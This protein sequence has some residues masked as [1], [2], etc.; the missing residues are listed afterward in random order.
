[1]NE[2]IKPDTTIKIDYQPS[3]IQ[4]KN[5]AE[6]ATLVKNTV[7]H[8]ESLTFTEGDIQG[9]KDAQTSLNKI[10]KLLNEKRIEVK[11]GYSE[12]L[13]AF[14]TKIKDFVSQIEQAKEGIAQSLEQFETTEREARLKKV[15]VK[16]KELCSVVG[17]D[18]EEIKVPDQW[19]NKGAFTSTKGELKAAT[20]KEITD[21]INGIVTERQTL[22]TNKQVVET[23]AEAVG[24]EPVSWVRWLDQGHELQDVLDQ[25]KQ[26]VAEKQQRLE[27]AAKVIEEVE[28][29]N[30][31]PSVVINQE[32]GETQPA[33]T[34]KAVASKQSGGVVT[35]KLK[36]T[37]E[38]FRL[39]NK[40]I[41]Q[42]RIEVVEAIE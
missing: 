1:M 37:D 39:L 7:N 23:Y 9:A 26:V 38:Q 22:A 30:A 35:L 4:I 36:G 34:Q 12:P 40:S 20:I 28:Q 33:A 3:T 31:E 25:I 11:K 8:Y 15:Q 18:P 5:E 27:K 24:L 14:E 2:L 42:L 19:T 16:I 32:T 41:V 17:I 21:T 6:L 10:V 13:D 29:K